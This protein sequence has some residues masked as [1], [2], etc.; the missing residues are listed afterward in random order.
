VVVGSVG[1]TSTKEAIA[2]VLERAGVPVRKTFGNLA[3]D[4]GVPLSLLGYQE[5]PVGV[6]GWLGAWFRSLT[7]RGV[8]TGEQRPYYVLEYSTDS[9]GDTDFLAARIPPHIVVVTA[10]TPVH[11]EQY[12]TEEVMVDET[13]SIVKFLAE[14]GIIIAH[15]GDPQQRQHLESDTRVRWYGL[16]GEGSEGVLVKEQR[17]TDGKITAYITVTEK[18]GQ[19]GKRGFTVQLPVYALHQLLPIAAAAAV[20]NTVGMPSSLVRE[21]LA[22]YELPAGRGRLIEGRRDVTI[23]DDSANSSPAAVIAGLQSLAR[24]AGGTRRSVAILGNMNELGAITKE[25]HATIAREA[26]AHAAVLVAVGPHAKLMAQEAQAAGMGQG[27]VMQFQTPESLLETLQQVVR[28]GDVVL[29]KASQNGMYLERVVASL[30]AEPERA[31]ELL[32]RQG[33]FWKRKR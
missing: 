12:G 27:A 24:L 8:Y 14:D 18:E 9:V 33:A 17:F 22:A 1:K 26:A 21:G 13:L 5:I 4:M 6:F 32:V 31:T 7:A 2:T 23:I 29:V 3:T 25:A 28:R 19:G 10:L 20:G 16:A 30:M 15:T 11:M